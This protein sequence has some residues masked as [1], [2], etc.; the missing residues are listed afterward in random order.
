MTIVFI[1][2][3]Y[4]TWYHRLCER[5]ANRELQIDDV[6]ERHHIIPKSLGGSNEA[7]NL[8]DLTPREHYVAHLM[9]CRMV[10]GR[11]KARMCYAVIRMMNGKKIYSKDYMIQ[12]GVINKW[13][14]GHSFHTLES[15]NKI[16]IALSGEKNPMYGVKR[17]PNLHFHGRRHSDI[18]KALFSAQRTGVKRS[19]KACEAVRLGMIGREIKWKDKISETLIN[20][21][22]VTCPHCTKVGSVSIMKRWHFDRCKNA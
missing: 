22:K 3:K 12:R 8:V 17:G 18:T 21:P 9:L 13:T 7:A 15:R 19:E 14:K 16:S 1:D 11:D 5:A 6:R 4:T 10:V 20:K 2:N